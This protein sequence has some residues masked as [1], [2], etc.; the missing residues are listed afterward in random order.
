MQRNLILIAAALVSTSA[1]AQTQYNVSWQRGVDA[2]PE[3]L[4]DSAGRFEHMQGSFNRATNT[5]SFYGSF[6]ANQGV[7]PDGFWLVVS[8]G[9]NP[10]GHESELAIFYLDASAGK[11]EV[12]AYAYNG[13]NGNNSFKDGSAAG[14]TQAP[15]KIYSSKADPSR[16]FDITSVYNAQ[17][18][19]KT[20]GFSM[21][22]SVIQNHVPKY[23]T[24]QQK[25]DWTG[26]A[27]GE[28]IGI[29]WHPVSGLSTSTSS[30]YLS[31]FDYCEQGW[32]DGKDMPTNPV[33]EPTTMI[34]LGAGLV[35]S[36][37]RRNRKT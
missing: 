17:T 19:T 16:M 30:N 36:L 26:A 21:D 25:S 14:G 29:W 31:K 1:L 35:A 2:N 4:N 18:N 32:F 33:P 23:G 20:L 7:T 22:A 8:P 34:A 27:F 6:S 3:G 15:D 5:F 9:P 13:V 28:N 12:Y 10:K 37:R 11:K 24:P